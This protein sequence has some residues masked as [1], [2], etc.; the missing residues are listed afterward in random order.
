MGRKKA[1]VYEDLMR[2]LPKIDYD[3][4][5]RM[6]ADGSFEVPE[7]WPQNWQWLVAIR[8]AITKA[9]AHEQM[10]LRLRRSIQVFRETFECGYAWPGAPKNQTEA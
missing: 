7:G 1:D 2:D 5:S 4:A 3:T 9:Q 10:A 8:D 6:L